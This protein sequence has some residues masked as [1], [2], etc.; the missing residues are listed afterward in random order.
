MTNLWRPPTE[1]R[2]I[3]LKLRSLWKKI[4]AKSRRKVTTTRSCSS[5]KKECSKTGGGVGPNAP[6]VYD[7]DKEQVDTVARAVGGF[8]KHAF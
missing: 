7:P 6:Q 3:I 5:F 4:K 2:W 8:Y 1:V